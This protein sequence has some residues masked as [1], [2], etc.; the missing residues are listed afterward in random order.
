M[1]SSKNKVLAQH[2]IEAIFNRTNID[3]I[4]ELI[5][6]DVLI[7]DTDKELAGLDQLRQ[8][9]MNLHHAF[10]DLHYMVEDLLEDN[11]RV[12]IRYKGKGTHCGAFRGIP[13]TGK[14]M[15][16]TGILICRFKN[17]RL[18]EHWAVSDVLGMLQQLGVISP[19]S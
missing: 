19:A 6:E 8:G 13:P 3:V 14:N 17:G 18:V 15:T 2:I 16:Y 5:A 1:S 9:I 12:V 4:T 7:H 11:D 10:P